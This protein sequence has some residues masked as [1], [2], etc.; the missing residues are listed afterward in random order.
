[1]DLIILELEILSIGYVIEFVV[2]FCGDLVF[3]FV[4]YIYVYVILVGVFM[5]GIWCFVISSVFYRF[6]VVVCIFKVL[7]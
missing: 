2:V 4:F 7:F 6:I 5:Y 1:M 3:F